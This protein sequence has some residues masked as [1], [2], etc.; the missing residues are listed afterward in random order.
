MRFFFVLSVV[1]F[2][3]S[4]IAADVK[5]ELPAP[6]K[7]YEDSVINAF[8][9]MCTVGTLDFDQLSAKASAMRMVKSSDKTEQESATATRQVQSWEGSL[10]DGPWT[11]LLEK[12]V[13]PA[14]HANVCGVAANIDNKADYR[15]NIIQRLHLKGDGDQHVFPNGNQ[16]TYWKNAYGVGTV[17]SIT[18]IANGKGMIINYTVVNPVA[19]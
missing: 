10:T 9:V 5:P 2:S 13:S 1:L 4:A 8:Q 12:I 6:I 3:Y 11:L 14:V 7:T 19:K 18:E 16:E 17:I 15:A